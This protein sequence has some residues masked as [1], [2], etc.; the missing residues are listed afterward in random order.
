MEQ[1]G[2]EKRE[3]R[4]NAVRAGASGRAMTTAFGATAHTLRASA[5]PA[6]RA[7][8]H[9]Q[10]GWV[11]RLMKREGAGILRMLWRLLGR[12]ADVMDAYQ[13]CFCKL[14]SRGTRGRI[15]SARAYAYR[16]ASNIAI[17]MIR[18]RTRR[19][20]HLPAI[21]M[22]HAH[23]RASE[24]EHGEQEDGLGAMRAAIARLPAHLR[25]VVV[26]RDLSRLSYARVGQILGIE[27]ATARVYRRHAVVKLAE[28]LDVEGNAS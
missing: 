17:E 26:L 24:V 6:V 27:P 14:A 23:Q 19:R 25:N 16:T 10:H 12:E 22:E 9:S 1:G 21:A 4:A 20:G 15:I 11:I 13:D 2:T 28:F 3:H 5:E 8:A 7:S 18:V